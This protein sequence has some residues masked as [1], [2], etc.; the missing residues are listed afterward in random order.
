MKK[1][2]PYTQRTS[3]KYFNDI[4]S[5]IEVIGK[6]KKEDISWKNII[7]SFLLL[8]S[9]NLFMWY[10]F[11]RKY[12]EQPELIL[13]YMVIWIIASLIIWII[14]IILSIKKRRWNN[15]NLD[16]N[17]IEM[18]NKN[19]FKIIN[20]YHPDYVPIDLVYKVGMAKDDKS[21]T[22]ITKDNRSVNAENVENIQEVFALISSII[23]KEE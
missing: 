7:Y 16:L 23:N 17:V 6:R 21:I 18:I 4:V 13:K 8:L 15:N 10:C 3:F 1:D 2:N 9:L 12:K 19:T 5:S 20:S 11:Y 22:F 14:I